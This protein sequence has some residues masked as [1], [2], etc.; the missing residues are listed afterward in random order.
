MSPTHLKNS[1]DF[2]D[3]IKAVDHTKRMISFD[4]KSLFTNVPIDGATRV[5]QVALEVVEDIELTIPKEDYIRLVELC[6]KFGS[7]PSK[8]IW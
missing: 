7:G 4:A 8:V 2:L 5:L 6:M 3:K 1:A